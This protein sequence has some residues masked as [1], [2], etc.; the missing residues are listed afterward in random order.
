MQTVASDLDN[1]DGFILL[2]KIMDRNNRNIKKKMNISYGN[3]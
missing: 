1:L 2:K 3:D